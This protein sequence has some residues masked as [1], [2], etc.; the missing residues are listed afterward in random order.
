M[1]H[2][3]SSVVGLLLFGLAGLIMTSCMPESRSGDVYTRDQARTSHSVYFGTVLR[4]EE[5]TIEGTQT[6]AGT[7]AGGAM[8][9][10]LGSG[11]G[12]GSGKT[13]AAVAGGILGGITGSAVEKG[14]TTTAGLEIEV[15]LD[16]GELILVVQEK[17]DAYSVGDR[18]RVI[19]DAKGTTRIRQ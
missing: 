15:E 7:V 8:G 2:N 9:A 17:D 18:V 19:K 14:A 5:V 11:V 10:A 3:R 6:G 1:K 4:V 12:S 13:M 16:S